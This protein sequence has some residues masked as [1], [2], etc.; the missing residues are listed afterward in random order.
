M[1]QLL[2]TVARFPQIKLPLLYQQ[3]PVAGKQGPGRERELSARLSTAA[4]ATVDTT[5]PASFLALD[6]SG[7]SRGD[8]V[9]EFTGLLPSSNEHAPDAAS[10]R[11]EERAHCWMRFAFCSANGAG[12]GKSSG[13]AR[14]FSGA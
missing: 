6:V 9:W 12:V 5:G 14:C 4:A 1:H 3:L 7:H 8:E 10:P 11:K 13:A 2:Y